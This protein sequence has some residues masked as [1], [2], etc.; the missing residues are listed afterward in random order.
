MMTFR[1]MR[2]HSDLAM[3]RCNSKLVELLREREDGQDSSP[4]TG[5]YTVLVPHLHPASPFVNLPCESVGLSTES[6][7]VFSMHPA[8]HLCFLI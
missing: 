2:A 7:P 1:A 3:G 8:L 6:Q 5:P 4:V